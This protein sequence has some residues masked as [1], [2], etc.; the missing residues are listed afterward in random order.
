[1]TLELGCEHAS[2]V[3]QYIEASAHQPNI[4]IGTTDDLFFSALISCRPAV[5]A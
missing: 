5:I 2:A 4:P 3:E 1:M